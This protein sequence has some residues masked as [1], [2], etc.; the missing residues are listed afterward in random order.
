MYIYIYIY[1]LFIYL[2]TYLATVAFMLL[3][4]CLIQKKKVY[5][6][7]EF[8]QKSQLKAY[9][10]MNLNL[11]KKAKTDFEKD[12][13]K[14]INNGVFRKIT[15]NVRKNRDIKLGTTEEKENFWY[16]NQNIIQQSFFL[17]DY[18][19]QK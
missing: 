12:F 4:K 7:I 19:Q 2:S 13:S 15:E 10:D 11:I 17:K 14:L 16:Q 18:Q 5:R 3:C 9:I 6:I 1:K 8:N